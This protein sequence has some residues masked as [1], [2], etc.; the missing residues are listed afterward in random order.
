[1][2]PLMSPLIPPT[3]SLSAQPSEAAAISE[4]VCVD[5]GRRRSTDERQI[6]SPSTEHEFDDD[7]AVGDYND[8][9]DDDDKID[10]DDEVSVEASSVISRCSSVSRMSS[11]QHSVT[12]D[13][14]EVLPPDSAAVDHDDARTSTDCPPAT[15]GVVEPPPSSSPVLAISAPA[16]PRRYERSPAPSEEKTDTDLTANRIDYANLERSLEEDSSS[17][18]QQTESVKTEELEE[19]TATASRT[20]VV[21]LTSSF[22]DGGT[23][24]C[25][26]KDVATLAAGESTQQPLDLTVR[27]IDLTTAT[28]G[29]GSD[30]ED[31]GRSPTLPERAMDV[32]SPLY[33][34]RLAGPAPSHHASA[35]AA[36]AAAAMS[37]RL[38]IDQIYQHH[39]RIIQ[40]EK[41]KLAAKMLQ[42]GLSPAKF[43]PSSGPGFPLMGLGGG[44]GAGGGGGGGRGFGGGSFRALPS[45]DHHGHSRHHHHHHHHHHA[46][47]S[48]TSSLLGAAAAAPFGS[49]KLKDRYAC[50][51]CGKVFP[52]S[53]NLTRHLRTHTGE[54]PYKC[55]YC[56]RQFSISSNLQRHVRNIHN[57]VNKSYSFGA[58]PT[59]AVVTVRFDRPSVSPS[60]RLSVTHMYCIKTAE[61]IKKT[62]FRPGSSIILAL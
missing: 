4:E 25:N 21:A 22:T 35:A 33:L 47:K 58:L 56:E 3:S 55:K 54:Q 44:A 39:H 61:D 43:P 45:P 10:E 18:R 7:D 57:K 26:F 46:M 1:M 8:D 28:H 14:D 30:D 50:R 49:G 24:K 13:V 40:Q 36:A 12:A 23:Q 62:F 38:I 52:R 34:D 19:K 15:C 5:G 16:S 42:A 53:A 51:Y 37:N 41:A 31:G 9:D 2:L 48:Q 32:L 6:S 27:Q 20:D 59:N 11:C 60:V 29:R 17:R